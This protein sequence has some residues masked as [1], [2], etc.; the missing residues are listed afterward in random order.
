MLEDLYVF[1]HRMMASFPGTCA[2]FL[3]NSLLHV[4]KEAADRKALQE[5]M[6]PGFDEC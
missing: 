1:H 5:A 6:Q 3:Q 2:S 4:A